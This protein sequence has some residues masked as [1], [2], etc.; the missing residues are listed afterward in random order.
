MHYLFVELAN[1]EIN[2]SF[3]LFCEKHGKSARDQ[4]FSCVSQ[5]L[6]RE[7]M[8]SQIKSSQEIV[9]AIEKQQQIANTFS[10]KIND[11]KKASTLPIKIVNTKAFVIPRYSENEY[12][13]ATLTVKGLKKYYNFFNDDNFQ[14]RT[15]LMSD[16]LLT[17]TPL[18][19]TI[20]D[21][22]TVKVNQAHT[23]TIQPFKI[24]SNTFRSKMFQWKVG[25]RTTNNLIPEPEIVR[26][27]ESN[28]NDLPNYKFCTTKCKS[29][30]ALC[31]FL[32]SDLNADTPIKMADINSELKAHGHPV[33]RHSKQRGAIKKK[34]RSLLQAV[35]E[36]KNHYLEYHIL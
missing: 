36:L 8:V 5:F 22:V 26:L 23:Q 30:D 28:T 10:S 31:L 24:N 25:Q 11:L 29:C 15:H 33:S 34:A 18:Q 3:N 13:S 1:F 4:H 20:N 7:S 2:V 12:L 17:C 16:Q 35:S 14:L 6:Y 21:K 27:I 19:Y 32:P 9:L